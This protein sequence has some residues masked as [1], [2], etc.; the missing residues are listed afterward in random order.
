MKMTVDRLAQDISS[1]RAPPPHSD[2]I[3]IYLGSK[4]YKDQAQAR[5]LSSTRSVS[6]SSNGAE[7][8]SGPDGQLLGRADDAI[9]PHAWIV[10]YIQDADA[11]SARQQTVSQ[12]RRV[13]LA[14]SHHYALIAMPSTTCATIVEASTGVC[15]RQK[16]LPILFHHH[17]LWPGQHEEAMRRGRAD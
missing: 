17:E 8:N 13:R 4:L 16:A 3:S 12:P 14:N 2:T 15:R 11:T 10:A 9:S 5:R 1:E 6:L 7:S